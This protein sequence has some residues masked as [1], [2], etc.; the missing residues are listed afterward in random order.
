MRAGVEEIAEMFSG[1]ADCVRTDDAD[2]VE[3][4]CPRFAHKRGL[5][6][7]SGEF[8]SLVQKSRST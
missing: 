3:T 7:G 1:F 4:E 2:A 6:V 5:Q 8:D